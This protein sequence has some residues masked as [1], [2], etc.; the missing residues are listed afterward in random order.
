MTS[1]KMNNIFTV[2]NSVF[3]MKLFFYSK[4]PP[5]LYSCGITWPGSETYLGLTGSVIC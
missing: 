1:V 2:I 4:I 3:T 5:P